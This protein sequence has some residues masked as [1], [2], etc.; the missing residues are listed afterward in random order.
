MMKRILVVGVVLGVLYMFFGIQMPKYKIAKDLDDSLEKQT[1]LQAYV[2]EKENDIKKLK[3]TVNELKKEKI[4]FKECELDDFLILEKVK[5]IE[6]FDLIKNGYLTIQDK[7]AGLIALVLN[8]KENEHVLDACSSPGGKTT[9]MAEMMNN[10]GEIVAWDIHEHRTK[11]VEKNAERL[12]IKIINTDVKN[13]AEYEEKYK[14]KFDRILLDVPCM[15]IGVIKRKPDIKW[16]RKKEDIEEISHLQRKILDNCSKYLKRGGYLVYS[17]CS[18]L[19]EENEDVVN[20]FIK[21][22]S[23]FENV[24][25]GLFN[26]KPDKEKDGFFICKLHKK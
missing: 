4:E 10:R 1:Q 15:G 21:N 8:P 9:Y 20:D 18:I 24:K 26:I 23:D 2:N 6:K 25:N 16:Q 17:T 3:K 14:E 11:L 19:K 7:G 13:S 12:G 22:N 5:N